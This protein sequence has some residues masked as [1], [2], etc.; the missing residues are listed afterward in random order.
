MEVSQNFEGLAQRGRGGKTAEKSAGEGLLREGGTG[1]GGKGLRVAELALNPFPPGCCVKE[2][3]G[4]ASGSL[5]AEGL[6]LRS[7]S[8]YVGRRPLTRGE[9]GGLLHRGLHGGRLS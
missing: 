8:R 5:A 2:G 1:P 4:R 3:L 7:S 9:R 6:L